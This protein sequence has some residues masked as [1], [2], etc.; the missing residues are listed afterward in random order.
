MAIE[1]IA[2]EAALHAE[3]KYMEQQ[4]EVPRMSHN[5]SKICTFV[6][7]S[8]LLGGCA[9]GKRP[10]LMVKMCLSNEQGVAEFID[11]L[12]ATASAEKLEFVDNSGNAERELKEAGYA[13]RERTGGSRVIDVRV[14]RNDGMGIGAA[15]VGLPGFQMAMGFSKGSNALEAQNFANRTLVRFRKH[16]LVESVPSGAGAK[17]MAGC[18]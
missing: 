14:I 8:L 15:N 6:I 16:W 5:L 10:F 11:E 13:G 18:R 12:K 1:P 2:I 7:A 17:P 3:H 9:P 4:N